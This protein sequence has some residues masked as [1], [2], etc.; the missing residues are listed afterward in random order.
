MNRLYLAFVAC[1]VFAAL[2][3]PSAAGAEAG[4][5]QGVRIGLV[6]P[7]VQMGSGDSAQASETIRGMLSEYLS[8]PTLQVTLL[9]ARLPEQFE[10][11]ARRAGCDYILSTEVVHRRSAGG[12]GVLG[13]ALGNFGGYVP[14]KDAVTS[15]VLSGAVRTAAD[16]A[17]SVKAKDEMQLEFLLRQPGAATPV[18]TKTVKGRARSDGE[19]I[20]TPLVE[21]AAAEIGGAVS[22]H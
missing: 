16:V 3:V 11:E 5:S 6:K 2:A 17:T 18:L 15:L 14:A 12:G 4:A 13:R 1:G 8:G 7:K 9:E 10:E 20:L 21:G 19:D 22:Q